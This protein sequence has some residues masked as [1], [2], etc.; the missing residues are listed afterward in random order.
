M[1]DTI[2]ITG[3]P[4]SGT[5][6]TCHLLNKL[7]N[8]VALHEPMRGKDMRHGEG[9]CAAVTAFCAEQRASILKAGLAITKH[10]GG[11]VPANPVGDNRTAEGYRERVVT[12]GEIEIDKPVDPDF[13]LAVKH[14]GSFTATLDRLVAEFP[15]YGL[16]RNPLATLASWSSVDFPIRQGRVP[17]AERLDR[18]LEA[19]LDQIDD[20]LDRQLFLL[21]WFHERMRRYLPEASI[22]RYEA[23]VE[24][25]GAALAVMHPAASH[26]SEDLDSQNLSKQYDRDHMLRLGE[27][28][29]AS[30]G[31]YWKSYDRREVENLLDDLRAL[32][33]AR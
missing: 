6:L 15:V 23:V 25:G 28:L 19:T 7:P 27:R 8:T 33:V 20:T 11:A 32:P 21:D 13:T 17:T 29:L 2:L 14:C 3:T 4:R 10:A 22:V 1:P 24:T 30:D 12:K 16:V 9:I 5:T 18:E 31:A 26:L